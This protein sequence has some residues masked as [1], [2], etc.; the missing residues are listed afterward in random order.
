[1]PRG[2]V[3]G[4]ERPRRPA[5]EQARGPGARERGPGPRWG[6]KPL[7]RGV[8][9]DPEGAYGGTCKSECR[10]DAQPSRGGGRASYREGATMGDR[11]GNTSSARGMDGALGPVVTG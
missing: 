1:M 10:P 11:A 6:M 7:V 9:R 8:V 2:W 4:A 5:G 3:G